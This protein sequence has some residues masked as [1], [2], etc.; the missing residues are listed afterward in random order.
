M[1]RSYDVCIDTVSTVALDVQLRNGEITQR[2]REREREREQIQ[3]SKSKI[4]TQTLQRNGRRFNCLCTLRYF[5]RAVTGHVE[6]SA[7]CVCI[8]VC[9]HVCLEP[10]RYDGID[11]L[12][13]ACSGLS[14]CAKR[15][16]SGPLTPHRLASPPLLQLHLAAATAGRGEWSSHRN[17]RPHRPPFAPNIYN[18][19]RKFM[20]FD[21]ESVPRKQLPHNAHAAA[22]A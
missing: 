16:H 9:V 13:V 20:H 10:T 7:K 21:P 17:T 12:H 2:E 6:G 15:C 18:K 14:I 11:E 22:G 1:V 4:A 8:C 5:R 19:W 3:A